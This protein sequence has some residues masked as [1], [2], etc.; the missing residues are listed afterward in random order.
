VTLRPH[1]QTIKFAKDKIDLIL[2]KHSKNN[3]FQYEANIAGQES[4]HESDIMISDWSGAALDY[5]FGLNKPV[6]FVDVPRKVNNVDYE[7]LNMEP[8]E[9]MIREKIGNILDLQSMNLPIANKTKETT[10]VFNLTS[11]NSIGAHYIMEIL[12]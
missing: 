1:P 12:K 2:K 10:N 11:S 4:L 5:A 3:L 6:W 9:V 8:F 7:E